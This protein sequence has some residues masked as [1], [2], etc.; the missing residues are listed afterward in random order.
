MKYTAVFSWPEGKGPR[1][2]A[3]NGWLGGTL[4][5]VQFSDG[6]LEKEKLLEIIDMT[7]D[8]LGYDDQFSEK[9][10]QMLDSI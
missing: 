2:S 6:L 9:L 7:I 1:V 8:Y 5:E 10:R 3:D 4:C